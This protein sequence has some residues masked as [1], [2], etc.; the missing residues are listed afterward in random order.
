MKIKK[1]GTTEYRCKYCRNAFTPYWKG[2]RG[3]TREHFIPKSITGKKSA[4]FIARR[5]CNEIK[6]NRVFSSIRQARKFILEERKK[7]GLP[8]PKLF[9]ASPKKIK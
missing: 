6:A 7:R 4:D 3:I 9:I 2:Y 1:D 5:I 8:K